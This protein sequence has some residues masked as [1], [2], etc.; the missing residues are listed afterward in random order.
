MKKIISIG[1]MIIVVVAGMFFWLTSDSNVVAKKD[2]SANDGF[3]NINNFKPG[4]YKAEYD[5]PDSRGWK[6]FFVMD[7]AENGS[8]KNIQYDYLRS[9]GQMKTKDAKY[10]EAMIAK[11]GIGPMQY[12]PRLS[13]S[14]L[15][16]GNPD[17]IDNI[18]GA[19]HSCRDFKL[20]AKKVFQA[21]KEGT[22]TTI[23]LPQPDQPSTR[24][25]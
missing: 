20:F 6:A 5:S 21:A 13:K 9:D 16:F 3:E 22:K 4:V 18:T 11:N 12:V 14:L 15:V 10:N 19:T 17:E 1:A 8:V 25:K 23:V 7:V 2:M 24:A